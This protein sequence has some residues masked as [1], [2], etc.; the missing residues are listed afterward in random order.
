[1]TENRDGKARPRL[2]LTKRLWADLER[3]WA[4]RPV[5][6]FLC[7]SRDEYFENPIRV[8]IPHLHRIVTPTAADKTSVLIARAQVEEAILSVRAGTHPPVDDD[9]LICPRAQLLKKHGLQ[10][11]PRL[12]H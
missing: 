11:I 8:L 12:L 10:R 2:T 4:G 3:I 9:G 7:A 5:R 1:M 6:A